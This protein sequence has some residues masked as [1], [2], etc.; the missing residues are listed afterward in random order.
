LAIYLTER[1][2]RIW[3]FSKQVS[4]VSNIKVAIAK[5]VTFRQGAIDSEEQLELFAQAIVGLDLRAFQVAMC[6]LSETP[7]EQGETAFPSLGEIMEIMEEAREKICR[8]G[9][10]LNTLPVYESTT[11][12]LRA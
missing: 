8:V 1:Q 9:S 10:E 5:M 3:R 4:D 11:K 6:V 12:R 7:R 2:E